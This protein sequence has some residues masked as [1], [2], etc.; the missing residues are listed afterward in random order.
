MSTHLAERTEPLPVLGPR[1]PGSAARRIGRSA[2]AVSGR[3][4]TEE[5]HRWFAG[6]GTAGR[7]HVGRIPFA[8]L[9]GWSFEPGTGNLVHASGRFFSVQGLH[10]TVDD[11]PHKEW[12]Q[13]IIKQPEVG[14][15][16][17]LAKEFDGVLHFLMQAKM[18]PGNRNVLQLSPTVQA[19]RSNYTKV[20]Q[21]TDVKYIRYFTGP[22]RG[23]VLADVLQSEHGSWFH[24]KSNRNMIVEVDGEVP[25]DEDFC[26]LTLGQISALLHRDN[27][28]NMDSRTVLACLPAY[29]PPPAG[30]AA[31]AFGR[32]LARSRDPR[33]GALHSDVDLL[34]W[35]TAERSRYDVRA[36]R[37][38]LGA[39][40]GWTRDTHRIGKDDG[41]WFDVVA[42][43]VQ[44][45][46]REVTG[47][48]Q[49]LIEPRSR[50]IAAFLARPIGGV[51]HVLAHAK[52][53]GGFLDTVELAPTVQCSPENFAGLDTRPPFLDL[54]L[55]AAPGRIRY[56][57]VHS[58]EGGRF[59]YAEN[60][61]LV[62]EAAPDEAPLDPPAGY[63][64][65]TLGQLTA[66]VKHGHY[67][68]VQA[69]TLLAC[70]N[71]MG[72]HPHD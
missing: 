45:G 61:Y 25:D 22:G 47:W 6:R 17:I 68:N 48:T 63:Q 69:R 72:H 62:V 53:E 11:G 46:N 29:E 9:R 19:T 42:V 33:A 44:A 38:P 50:G 18:E 70:L 65:V 30:P 58:E 7:F 37:V 21:G 12:Y 35:F 14:I 2:A 26:W 31:D 54:V 60:R 13:P 15:L 1:E 27:L 49:P 64:W 43:E 16:G 57:A 23:R 55:S 10:V 67:V 36:E 5:F 8:A 51:L 39:L 56:D 40:P 4:S 24:H 52:V 32:A 3:L 41:R 71:A 66:L 20:H 28:V 34:S 59:L